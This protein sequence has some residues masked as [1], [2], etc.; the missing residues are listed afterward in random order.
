MTLKR[1]AQH[2]VRLTERW[3]AA[4][5]WF[6]WQREEATLYRSL[7]VAMPD[8]GAAAWRADAHAILRATE[9]ARTR[10]DARRARRRAYCVARLKAERLRN[11]PRFE[12][13]RN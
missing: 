8:G 9:E 5:T 4:Q 7:G 10:D 6:A 13:D 2:R 11:R 12:V 3:Q 1:R